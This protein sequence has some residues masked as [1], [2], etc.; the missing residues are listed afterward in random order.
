MKKIESIK[1]EAAALPAAL[2]SALGA[3]MVL[4][5]VLLAAGCTAVPEPIEEPPAGPDPALLERAGELIQGAS[6]E[7]LREAVLMLEDPARSF[8]E[9]EDLAAFA[10]ALFD[11]LY[12]QLTESG[13]LGAGS[14]PPY[15][16]AY[17]RTLDRARAGQPPLSGLP[18]QNDAGDEFFDLV[19]PALFLVRPA[20]PA[21]LSPAELSALFGLLEQARRRNR[22][23][24]LPLYLQG[25]IRELEGNPERAAALYQESL[26]RAPS[27]YPAAQALAVLLLKQGEAE[28]AA[29]L[30]EQI[31]GRLPRIGS[32]EYPLAEAYYQTGQLEAASAAVARVLLEE[33]DRTDALLLRARVLAAEGNWNQ[34]LRLLNLLLYQHPDSQAAY[35]LGA[36]LRYEEAADPEGALELLTE[37]ENQFPQAAE[38]PELAGRIYLDTGRDGEGLNQLQRALDLDP[39]RVST[40]RLLLSN[41]MDMQRWLQS[42]IYLSQILEQEQSEQDLLQAIEI[43]RSLGD[44]AQVLYY[45]EQLYQGN[46]SV[47]NLVVYAQ[48][49]LAEGRGQQA[50]ALIE[51]GLE[52]AQTPALHSTLLTLQASMTE[53]PAKALGLV[54][55]A[56]MEY[57]RNYLALVK[58]TDLYVDQRELRK[59]SLY[60]KQAIALDPNNAA[61]R[62]RLQ[63]I[64]KALGTQERPGNSP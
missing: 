20:D 49:L 57:P 19:V 18:S 1:A 11:L 58:I 48:A 29:E 50:G 64:E 31:A 61:L 4:L 54:R 17:S 27:F 62:V 7:Q 21:A 33:P 46:P 63:S 10:V 2:L 45:A 25:R 59:A 39:G 42:A 13:Y 6:P 53:D 40:L 56:L 5:A 34:A 32:I 23:S 12:P 28:R 3:A 43:Y 24:A 9:A 37:A 16:G 44:P 22:S 41:A 36:R 60:L 47:D 14:I 51:Q 38:F 26:D 35:L 15:R 8:P 52:Q 30:L 55:E